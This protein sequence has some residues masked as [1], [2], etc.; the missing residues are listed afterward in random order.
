MLQSNNFQRSIGNVNQIMS[1]W[2]M[3]LKWLYKHTGM[4]LGH[5]Q[6]HRTMLQDIIHEV[7]HPHF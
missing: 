3:D 5:Y 2:Y 4:D 7:V 6:A 1:L